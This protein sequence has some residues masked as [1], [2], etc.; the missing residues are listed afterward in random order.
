VQAAAAGADLVASTLS[1]YTGPGPEP[2]EPDVD[3]VRRLAGAGLATVAEGRVRHPE[4]ARAARE[5]GAVA[6]VVGSAITRPEHVTR[7]FVDALGGGAARP[8]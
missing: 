1:G 2:A 7:W 3:L 4:Q 8:G 6:V 5:A